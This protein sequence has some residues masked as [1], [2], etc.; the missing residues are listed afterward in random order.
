MAFNE[1]KK[2]ELRGRAL[3][4]NYGDAGKAV[5]FSSSVSYP[6]QLGEVKPLLVFKKEILK[7]SSLKL[8]APCRKSPISKA[9]RCIS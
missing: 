3:T 8:N 1:V 5:T 4:T 6:S 9:V 2:S 7:S